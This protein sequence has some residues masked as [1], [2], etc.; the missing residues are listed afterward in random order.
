MITLKVSGGGG[1]R[2]NAQKVTDVEVEERKGSSYEK[3]KGEADKRKWASIC[4]SKNRS[5]IQHLHTCSGGTGCVQLLYH[6][7]QMVF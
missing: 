6:Q 7:D 5:S 1:G 4:D 3:L 2:L